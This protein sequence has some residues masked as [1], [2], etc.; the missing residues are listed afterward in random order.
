MTGDGPAPEESPSAESPPTA[1]AAN[2][3]LADALGHLQT[4][5]VSMVAAARA[6]LDAA[7]QL[8]RDP[9][10]LLEMVAD[11]ARAARTPTNGGGAAPGPGAGARSATSGTPP[12]PR[13]E[14]IAVTPPSAV[15]EGEAGG[16][17]GL[18]EGPG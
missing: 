15:I 2:Q 7:E 8:A 12:R 9:A 4:A 16:G 14:H 10:P 11:A 13:V 3:G 1:G 17:P 6:A 5:A 18:G